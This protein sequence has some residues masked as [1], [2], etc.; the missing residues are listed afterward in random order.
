LTIRIWD[1]NRTDDPLIKTFF[2]HSASLVSLILFS[3]GNLAS[4][5]EDGTIKIWHFD[6]QST[7]YPSRPFF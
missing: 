3:N 5:S 1:L 7:I 4:N 6:K 2:A